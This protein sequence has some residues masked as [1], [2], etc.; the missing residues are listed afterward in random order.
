MVQSNSFIDS[1]KIRSESGYL[2]SKSIL[3]QNLDIEN[4]KKYIHY[5]TSVNSSM[6]VGEMFFIDFENVKNENIEDLLNFYNE[7][8]FFAKGRNVIISGIKNCKI[9]DKEFFTS[10]GVGVYI[11]NK[12]LSKKKVIDDSKE[13]S[14][15]DISNKSLSNSNTKIFNG[16]IRGGDQVENDLGDIIII[17]SVNTGA[18]V[19]ASGN[20]IVLGSAKGS[21][22]AGINNDDAIIFVKEF[23]PTIISINGLYKT[24]EYNSAIYNSQNVLISLK[25]QDLS[26]SII[27]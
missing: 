27:T 14:I 22:Y 15:S 8:V 1:S 3:I 25:N 26:I 21:I 13:A 18:E 2:L 17:G 6:Y 4:L 16:I 7:S 11:D 9:K 20:V 10:L 23:K 5:N 24:V 19:Y 12:D